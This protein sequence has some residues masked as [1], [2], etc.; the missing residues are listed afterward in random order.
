VFSMYLANVREEDMEI[1]ITTSDLNYF[2]MS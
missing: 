2:S 1:R